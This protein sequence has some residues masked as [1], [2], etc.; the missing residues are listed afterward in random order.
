MIRCEAAL[1]T[2][3]HARG[4]EPPRLEIQ[5][6][7]DG[8]PD[9][10]HVTGT[11]YVEGLD[12]WRLDAL[13]AAFARRMGGRCTLS[14]G[15]DY[16]ADLLH[17]DNVEIAARRLAREYALTAD[18]LAARAGIAPRTAHSL[19]TESRRRNRTTAVA[20]ARLGR[21]IVQRPTVG[22]MLRR[23]RTGLGFRHR[24]LVAASIGVELGTLAAWEDDR[25]P[26]PPELAADVSRVLG[27]PEP[28]LRRAIGPAR[29]PEALRAAMTRLGLTPSA[30]AN[31]IGV[32]AQ[33]VQWWLAGKG[34]PNA[35]LTDRIGHITGVVP[36]SA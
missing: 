7:A 19:L 29:F 16:E 30:L 14:L 12:A 3:L 9:G 6:E 15:P 33:T 4:Y 20:I 21:R 1:H 2:T 34:M 13:E 32:S 23:Q 18:E 24:A 17:G 11:L 26:I 31:R 10:Y 36:D 35:R 27:L 8:G 28:E 5:L 25:A 22:E